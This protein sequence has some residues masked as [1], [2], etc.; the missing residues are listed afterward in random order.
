MKLLTPLSLFYDL[1]ARLRLSLYER[2]MK[3]S[4][5]AACP[6]VSVGNLTVG[7]TGKT[8]VVIDLARRFAARGFKP[9]VISRGYKRKSTQPTLVVSDGEKLA[10]VEESGDEPYLIAVSTGAIVI[11]GTDRVA[12]AQLAVTKYGANLIILDD[13]FQHLRLRRDLDILLWDMNDEPKAACLLPA[14][15]LREPL[16]ALGRAQQIV[17]TKG[18]DP[19]NLKRVASELRSFNEDAPISS[20][21]F[22]PA[23]L[24]E[25]KQNAFVD[26]DLKMIEGKSVLVF[27]GIARPEQLY[28]TVE[29]LGAKISA[30]LAFADHHWFNGGDLESL[31][32][33]AVQ[34][35]AEYFLTTEKDLVRLDSAALPLKVLAVRLSVE[36]QD[37]YPPL[38]EG[39]LRG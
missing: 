27:C 2:G 11:V 28:S 4:Y 38:L 18:G 29:A 25:F 39:F 23:A 33:L 26:H 15:R 6:V 9:A 34:S 32:R 13:G 8:P 24:C 12:S 16:S 14:G 10:S 21:R 17:L 3:K 5:K 31:A 1:G 22:V 19:E 37:Q 7:G 36:W 30:R 20:C 35:G